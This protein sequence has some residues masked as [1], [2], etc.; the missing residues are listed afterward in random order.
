VKSIGLR[1]VLVL[2]RGLDLVLDLVLDRG[3]VLG[4]HESALVPVPGPVLVLVLARALFR[5]KDAK[6]IAS[7]VGNVTW[8]LWKLG[9]RQ[10]D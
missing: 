9:S 7:P 1:L 10:A 6:S 3:L 4:R 2:D 5:R 8:I